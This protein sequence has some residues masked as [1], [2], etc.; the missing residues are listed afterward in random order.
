MTAGYTGIIKTGERGGNR[1]PMR[2][3]LAIE[4]A[5]LA[6]DG[7]AEALSGV[8]QE[9]EQEGEMTLTRII[10]ENEEGAEALGRP[11]GTYI[12]AELP[13]LTD[14]E[15]G[16]EEKAKRLGEELRAL[17][18]PEGAVLVIGLGNEAITPDALGPHAVHMVMATRHI[19]G[20]FARSI[21]LDDL[22]PAAVL[23]PGVLGRTG[24]ESGEIVRGV[25]GVI[26]PAAVI[27]VDALAA[28]SVARLGCTLQ[29]CDTGIAPGSGVGNNRMLLNAETLGVPVIGMG[30]PTVVDARTIALELTGRE[31]SADS[32]T[33]RGEA[34]MVTPREIDLLIGRASRLVAM[35]I[36]AALQPEYS[37]LSLIA[38]AK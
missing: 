23:S 12:T 27:V 28:R 16:M 3:D 8:R 26:R 4:A 38:A 22:R 34:M 24:M 11:L 21:G 10:I 1:M 29:L 19:E 17:L 31:E 33:P 18:P 2:T 32:V 30:V 6:Q 20:E 15:E 37:P 25:C 36:N 14:D 35:V 5:V 9:S 7:R 13:P